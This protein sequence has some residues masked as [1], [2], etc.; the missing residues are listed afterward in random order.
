MRGFRPAVARLSVYHDFSAI[1]PPPFLDAGL[2]ALPAHHVLAGGD[3]EA[4][5]LF[6]TDAAGPIG[7]HVYAGSQGA[8]F[9]V[10]L[11][12]TLYDREL[13]KLVGAGVACGAERSTIAKVNNS[14]H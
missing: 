14:G 2:V 7:L 8:A 12:T 1:A 10:L 3:A 9:L 4:L 11:P 6:R 5:W 13:P